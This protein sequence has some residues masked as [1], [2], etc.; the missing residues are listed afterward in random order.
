MA[1]DTTHASS[2]DG[3]GVGSKNAGVS[4]EGMLPK[5]AIIS[6][7]DDERGGD[8]DTL[9]AASPGALL[10][11]GEVGEGSKNMG[12]GGEGRDASPVRI[13]SVDG[14]IGEIAGE[15][16]SMDMRELGE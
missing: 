11:I 15:R 16:L 14:R 5:P 1:V 10:R 7:D 2:R 9:T 8:W 13:L 12:E 6:P 3:G 4:C